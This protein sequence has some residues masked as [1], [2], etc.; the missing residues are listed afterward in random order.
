MSDTDDIA[1]LNREADALIG[2]AVAARSARFTQD[3][4]R[5]L[6]RVVASMIGETPIT[7]DILDGIKE[8]AGKAVG[9]VDTHAVRNGVDPAL[10]RDLAGVLDAAF[11]RVVC[12]FLVCR[13]HD[14]GQA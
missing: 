8:A 2:Q 12:P 1:R 13:G 14:D 11:W 4:G 9:A 10:A 3:A 5:R 7:G 6:G